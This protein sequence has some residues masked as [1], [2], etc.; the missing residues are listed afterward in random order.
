MHSI[1]RRKE[2]KMLIRSYEK[3]DLKEMT[4]IWK[5]KKI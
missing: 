5:R 1:K 2:N 4:A 3:K